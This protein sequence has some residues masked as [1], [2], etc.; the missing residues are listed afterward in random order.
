MRPDARKAGQSSVWRSLPLVEWP[1]GD[2]DAWLRAIYIG[3]PL[4]ECG[5]AAL[6]APD[7]R[8]ILLQLHGMFLAWCDRQGELDRS[9]GPETRY[10]AHRLGRFILQR[11]QVLVSSV[12]RPC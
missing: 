5:W 12:A 3:G 9:A 6:L 8:R 1:K 2:G 11:R 10:T 7:T 4:N